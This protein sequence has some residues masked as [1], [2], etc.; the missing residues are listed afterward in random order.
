VTEAVLEAAPA[1]TRRAVQVPLIGLVWVVAAVIFLA[2]RLAPIWHTPV[3][4]AELIHLSGAWQARIGVADDRFVPTLFQALSALLLHWSSS[5]IPARILAFAATASIPAALYLLRSRLGEAGALLALI[6]LTFDGPAITAGASASAMGF[7]LAIVL[8]LFLFTTRER[9]PGWLAAIVGFGVAT[10]GPI[11]LPL[12]AAWAIVR[13]LRRSYPS[14]ALAAWAAGGVVAGVLA[15]TFRFG[16]GIDGGL[17]VPSFQLF[18]ASYDQLWSTTSELD[19]TL[20]YALPVLLGGLAAV[21]VA[22]SRMYRDRT[23]E[24]DG[25]VLVAWAGAAAAWWLS[26]VNSHTAT[27]LVALTTPLALILGPALVE[28]ITAMWRADWHY[29]R[30]L[31]PGALLLLAVALAVGIDWAQTSTVGSTSEKL[32]VA[33]LCVLAVAAFAILASARESLPT[34]F[35][36]LLAIAALPL[37]SGALG[38]A[39]ST[40]GEP[41]PSPQV[42]SQARELRNIALQSVHDNGGLVVINSAFKDELT[43]PFRD[44]GSIVVASRV[45]PDATFVIW[46]K[47]APAPEGFAPINGDWSLQRELHAPT[48][49][50]LTYL[51]WFSNRNVLSITS[52]P[53]AVYLRAKQ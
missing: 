43:W 14:P 27:P 38:V 5:E 9:V 26:S 11:V 42:A 45:P 36:G 1:E 19:M 46:P 2:L 3:A 44:S 25:L 50:F 21:V 34:V 6:L 8:W 12:V 48:A 32:A 47:D 20:L 28:A 29:A 22:V 7:D 33:G 35:A 15:A 17:R 23:A 24:T 49:D 30:W 41:T 52:E 31:V 51:R 39:L 13:L 4:G 37:F 18:A 16:L 40:N 10:G 53:V